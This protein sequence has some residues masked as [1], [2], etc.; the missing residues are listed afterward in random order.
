VLPTPSPVPV[1]RRGADWPESNQPTNF[2]PST[3]IE[4]PCA[5][6][7]VRGPCPHSLC[8]VVASPPSVPVAT[9]RTVDTS[10]PKGTCR[11]DAAPTS[12]PSPSGSRIRTGFVAAVV[13]E[14]DRLAV[15]DG[16]AD[17]EADAV[18]EADAESVPAVA[19]SVDAVAEDDGD[20]ELEDDEHA[21]RAAA[22]RTAGTTATRER[23]RMAACWHARG[24]HTPR[25]RGPG[26]A[27]G[28]PA[29]RRRCCLRNDL[30]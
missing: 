3:S 4:K 2:D 5:A 8:F 18:A 6:S 20:A 24:T 29:A 26:A 19:V 1:V 28:R 27:V 21:P 9:V 13:V 10:V 17:V 15:A 25:T 22:R 11:I 16:D 30:L 14:A 12:T 23:R 7:C